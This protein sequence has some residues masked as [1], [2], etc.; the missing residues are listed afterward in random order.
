MSTESWHG[1]LQ[2]ILCAIDEI[3]QFVAGM[4]Q[5]QFRADPR[6]ISAVSY[7]FVIIGEAAR[8]L[9]EEVTTQYPAVPW[10]KMKAMRNI[11]AHEYQRVDGAILWETAVHDLPG[12]IPLLHEILEREP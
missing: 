7:Q 10:G 9:P 12:L 6:T 2:D 1:R 5:G 4:D 8:H 3:G 11:I